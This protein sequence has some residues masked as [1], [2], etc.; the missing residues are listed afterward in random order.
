MANNRLFLVCVHCGES[1]TIARLQV[2]MEST[3]LPS[4][5]MS[6]EY[7]AWLSTHSQCDPDVAGLHVALD[8]ENTD[9]LWIDR[10]P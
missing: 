1:I 4:R 9:S 2:G 6:D 3:W 5:V 8:S 10:N 7:E